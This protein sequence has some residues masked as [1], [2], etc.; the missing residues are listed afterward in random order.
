MKINKIQIET[1]CVRPWNSTEARERPLIR[2]GD[3]AERIQACLSCPL[4]DC[5]P[6]ACPW[7][8]A[9]RKK[10]RKKKNGKK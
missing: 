2:A 6:H 4:P 5:S 9:E 8:W 7:M 3:S 1:S 10:E